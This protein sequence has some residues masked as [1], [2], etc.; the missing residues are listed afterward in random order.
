MRAYI[1]S[2]HMPDTSPSAKSNPS[3]VD[4]LKSQGLES[5]TDR[6]AE[7]YARFVDEKETYVRDARQNLALL[8]AMMGK[9]DL[10]QDIIAEQRSGKPTK[11]EPK[12]GI[13]ISTLP[14][15]DHSVAQDQA[16]V[17]ELVREPT[18]TVVSQAANTVVKTEEPSSAPTMASGYAEWI[19]RG[20]RAQTPE[21]TAYSPTPASDTAPIATRGDAAVLQASDVPSVSH[22]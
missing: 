16:P 1:K 22:V 8:R 10:L 14:A 15:P 12:K 6:R 11:D 18:P 3:I 13:A 5:S 17:S 2:I 4:F 21:P 9:R 20:S 7:Y 19:M